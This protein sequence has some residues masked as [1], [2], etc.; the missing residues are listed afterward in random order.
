MSSDKSLHSKKPRIFQ[1]GSSAHALGLALGIVDGFLV[2]PSMDGGNDFV[3]R[4]VGIS[5]GIVLGAIG[6]NLD[7][8]HKQHASP[9]LFPKL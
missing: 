7:P 9:A 8:P 2:S 6:V 1:F 5:D 4:E 3:G